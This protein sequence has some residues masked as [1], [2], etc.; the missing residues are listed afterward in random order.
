MA[1]RPPQNRASATSKLRRGGRHCPLCLVPLRKIAPRTRMA[2]TC[3]ACR[4]HPQQ[5]KTCAK[6]GR[7]GVWQSREEAACQYCG[8]H[9]KASEVIAS[10]PLVPTR[11]G[12]APVLAAQRRR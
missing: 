10:K 4:A 1:R 6:C 12:E 11:S 7:S 5:E 9:G 3:I 2:R 8:H